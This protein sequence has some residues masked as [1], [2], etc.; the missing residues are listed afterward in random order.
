VDLSALIFVALAVAWAVYLVPKALRAHEA[1]EASRG[2]ES[3]SGRLRVLSRRAPAEDEARAETPTP[4]VRRGASPAAR[5]RRVL[6][7]VLV[8]LL[9]FVV[10][11]AA[12]VL[13][14][15][16]IA[17]P[18]VVLVAWLVAC[19]LMVRNAPARRPAASP[20]SADDR[21]D[22]R[23]ASS[24]VEP[25]EPQ[26]ARV[27]TPAPEA[28]AVPT[29]DHT[30]HTDRTDEI[31]QVPVEF[32]PETGAPIKWDPV[33]VTLPTYVAKEPAARRSVSSIDLDSTGVWTSGRSEADSALAR[34]ADESARKVRAARRERDAA[35]LDER[36]RASGS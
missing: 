6:G 12:G 20:R 1:G 29:D 19:R 18:L 32:D 5:R 7:G 15:G 22:D 9:G 30:D 24:V 26:R 3:F 33:P 28:Q 31:A 34:E 36:R 4:P 23:P 25:G 10:L 17:V 21:S 35:E 16:W 13:A 11:A 27:E 8:A 14:W 2:V